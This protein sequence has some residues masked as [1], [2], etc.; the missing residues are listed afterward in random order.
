MARLKTIATKTHE[1][2]V[3]TVSELNSRA[4]QVLEN[5]L[6]HIWLEAEM[7]NI[8]M[9][10]SGH[11][12]F[13]LKDQN[14]QISC[15]MFK[16]SNRLTQVSPKDGIK[17]L[18]RG[19]VSLYEPR[20]NYQLIVDQMKLAG[21]GDLLAQF[22]ALKKKLSNEGLFDPSLKQPIEPI[23]NT[24][25]VITSPTGAAIHDVLS[26]IQRRF[27]LQKVILYPSL[28]QGAQAVDSLRKQLAVANA[29]N[30]VDVLLV[31]RGGGAIED[32]WSFNDEQFA[33]D[34]VASKI[35]VVSGVGHEVDFTIVDFVADLRAATPT[36]AA[37]KTTPDQHRIAQDLDSYQS[38]MT[39][40]MADKLSRSAQT[41]DWLTR[42]L[43]TPDLILTS[44]HQ[45]L[46][47]LKER[48]GATVNRTINASNKLLT[49]SHLKIA[50]QDPRR[51]IQ[52][53]QARNQRLRQQLLYQMKHTLQAAKTD[54]NQTI[55]KIDN[56]SPLKILARGYSV[57]QTD[58]GKIIDTAGSVAVGQQITTRLH[59]GQ[60]V[61][62]I[63]KIENED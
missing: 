6:M 52:A 40:F 27:P 46:T 58:D 38:W 33:R 44:R 45:Q 35:P 10:R 34:I 22:E 32:L 63:T 49:Q 23:Y 24:I 19:K 43:R 48:L 62:Q 8:T 51:K 18:V 14:S 54:F 13:T 4:R 29:R 1:R 36:A 20:G 42:Q 3:Y 47:I 5:E 12:Y 2:K 9:A 59:N 31:V 11:W 28:V 41:L 21:E 55:I 17:V 60:L 50:A 57:T 15:A 37:E 61:S 39:Q 26:T 53:T 30:E 25:G 16:G 56:L 7:S